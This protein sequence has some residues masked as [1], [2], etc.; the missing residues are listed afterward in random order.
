ME[1]EVRIIFTDGTVQ[2]V[3][4]VSIQAPMNDSSL[5]RVIKSWNEEGTEAVEWV[6]FFSHH[7]KQ[8][9]VTRVAF[10]KTE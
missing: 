9:D 6:D 1:Y 3:K 10:D 7:V 8:M 5:I 2:E 4:G